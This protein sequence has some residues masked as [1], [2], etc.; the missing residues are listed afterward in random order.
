MKVK[1][2]RITPG[3]PLEINKSYKVNFETEE[4][5]IIYNND[6]WCGI[7]KNNVEVI[8]EYYQL[9]DGQLVFIL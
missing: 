4:H 5:Y 1:I 9:G 3:V 8:N 6:I 7:Y 2:L